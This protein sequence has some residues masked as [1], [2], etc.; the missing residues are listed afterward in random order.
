MI[1]G[2]QEVIVYPDDEHKPPVGEGLNR[3]AR[4]NLFDVYPVD[5]TTHE[6][7]TDVRRITAMNYEEHLKQITSKFDGEFVS[8]DAKDGCW[9]FMVRRKKGINSFFISPVCPFVFR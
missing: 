7:I 1:I 8:Y 9:T 4:I 6:E 3:S 2:R 5:R